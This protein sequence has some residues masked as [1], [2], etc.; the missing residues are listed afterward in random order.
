M[1]VTLGPLPASL[2]VRVLLVDPLRALH[3]AAAWL[4]G[5]AGWFR[6][7][8][9]INRVAQCRQFEPWLRLGM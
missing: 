9:F 2:Q 5:K 1:L 8:S 4:L 6:F 3:E 7:G